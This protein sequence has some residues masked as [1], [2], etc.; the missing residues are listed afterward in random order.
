MPLASLSA[1]DIYFELTPTREWSATT[2]TIVLIHGIGSPLCQ[3]PQALV[4]TLAQAGYQVLRLDNRDAGKSRLRDAPRPRR[5]SAWELLR[6]RLGARLPAPYTLR[7]MAGDA[8]ELMDHLQL[9]RAHIVGASL[10]GMIAQELALNWPQR[11]HSLSLI[12][13]TSGRRAVG[14]ARPAT[15]R[16]LFAPLPG[17]DPESLVAHFADQFGALQGPNYVSP[18]AEREAQ[19]RANLAHGLNGAGFL[20]QSQAAL[21]AGSRE[22]RLR[23]LRV[24]SLVLHGTADPL[25]HVSGGKALARAIPKAKLELIEGWGHDF[26]ASVLPRVS[27]A[28]LRHFAGNN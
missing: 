25:I 23:K 13:S 11:V 19:A 21:N 1:A 20:R 9:E 15:L 3:W 16:K 24:P 10:G 28:L 18:L 14:G 2:Q 26:P 7:D 12:M 27:A 8:I 6:W 5:A 22:A 17:R 4:D